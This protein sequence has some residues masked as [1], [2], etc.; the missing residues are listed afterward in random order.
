MFF[1]H[2][3]FQSRYALHIFKSVIGKENIQESDKNTE[4]YNNFTIYF[5]LQCQSLIQRQGN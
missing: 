1:R 2:P 3:T 4:L 5:S